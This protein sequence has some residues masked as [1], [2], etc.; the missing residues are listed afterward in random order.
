MRDDGGQGDAGH[1]H[2][3][4]NDKNKVEDHV[5]RAGE[6]EKVEG[7]LGVPLGPEDGRAEVVHKV[8]GQA[9]KVDA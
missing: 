3:K 2:L 4:Q 9:Q 6:G 8:G 7:A 1:V 5:D